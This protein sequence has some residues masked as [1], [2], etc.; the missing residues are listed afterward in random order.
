MNEPFETERRRPGA[1]R[2]IL[3]AVAWGIALG[4]LV[5]LVYIAL[6]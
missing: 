5:T 3:T 4:F 6:R 2:L 1:M